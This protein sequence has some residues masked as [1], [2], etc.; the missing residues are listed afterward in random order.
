[1]TRVVGIDL[2]TT[3]SVISVIEGGKP[4]VIPNVEGSRITPSVVGFSKDGEIIV[5]EPA[6]RQA[7]SNPERTVRSI[8]RL[9]GT[10]ERVRIGDK[11]Y[12]PE[13][14]SA[15]IIQKMKRDGEAYLGEE[16]K[17]AVITVPAYFNDNQR[18]STKDAGRIAGLEVLRIINEPTASSLAYGLDKEG[19]AT[20]LVFDLGGGTFDVSILEIGEGVFEVKATSGNTRLGGDDWDQ[21]IIDFL[22]E[23]F[24]KETGIDLTKDKS[25]MQR[26]KEAAEKAK[27]ELS[28]L[29]TTTI[30]LP[31]ISADSKGPKH[32]EKTIN[33]AQFENMTRDLLDKVKGP[34]KQ[35]LEDAKLKPED[36]E[37]ILLV[38]GA[39][40]MPMVQE[41]IKGFFGKEPTKDINPD[42]C[43]AV[44]A[45]IQAGVLAGDVSG[46][47]LLD[48]TPLSLGVETL[49]A[50]FTKLIERNTTI[51]T[52]KSQIFTTASDN[53]TSVDI[54]VLQGERPMA[55]DNVS[56][57][58]FQLVGIPPAP[59][60]IPQIEVTFDIDANGI[61]DVAAKD[62]ATGKKQE[63]KITPSTRLNEK[64]IERMVKEAEE[65]AEEDRRRKELAETKNQ[66]DSL[67]YAAEK[68]LKDYADKITE[69]QK[70]DVEKAVEKLR[71]AISGED[72]Q[73]IKDSMEELTKA[74]HV[75]STAM[76]Q[77]E[78]EKREEKDTDYQE[79]KNDS[80]DADYEVVNE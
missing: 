78:A 64:D 31:F 55:A 45:T 38:G 33:R 56:L 76:Y 65:H 26:L 49:G 14:I 54:N 59:R 48:V 19:E 60:G 41:L 75:I 22:V 17:K 30:N 43:V 57:G 39:T 42:E 2:G 13:E 37:K 44:G 70:E 3:N 73:M 51:P 52:K 77:A 8:K 6:K 35:A 69:T 28:T 4:T 71:E 23:E 36:I 80:V 24:K 58:R 46:I 29:T 27:I 32:L 5:G 61:L 34:L 63:M 25:A 40:R 53:Q 21:K 18:A 11:E 50:V 74:I 66:A 47:V 10:N 7:I 79:K 16:I 1:M 62:L 20:I 9:M 15:I 68:M 67:I 72:I 12:T